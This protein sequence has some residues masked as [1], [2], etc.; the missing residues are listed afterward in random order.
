M[1]LPDSFQK[2]VRDIYL[3]LAEIIVNKKQSQPLLVSING[4]QGTGKSTLTCFMQQIIEVESGYH[5]AVLSLDDFYHTRKTR[6]DLAKNIHPLFLTRGVPGTHDLDTLENVI[7]ALRNN[8]TCMAPKFNKASDNPYHKSDWQTYDRT[9]D[10]ILFEGWCNNSPVQSTTELAQ[11]VNELEKKEDT[12]G[13]WRH[14]ANE[15]LAQYH[16]RVFDHADMCIM[17]QAPDFEHVFQWRSLQE[18]KLEA[19]T[20]DNQQSHIMN[21]TELTRFIQH[22]ERISRHSLHHLPGTADVILPVSADH[23]ITGIITKQNK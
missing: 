5:T 18:Q 3:P 23:T 10:I 20:P 17:L 1:K 2:I 9:I 8:E 16:Q 22:Y 11:P 7:Q 12:E 6:E 21:D 14:H 19:R 15:C 4:A 13:I